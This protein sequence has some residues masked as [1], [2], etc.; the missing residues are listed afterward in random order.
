M[1]SFFKLLLVMLLPLTA[2]AEKIVLPKGL[3]PAVL[4]PW[5]PTRVEL[6]AI[7]TGAPHSFD[8]EKLQKAP[9]YKGKKLA[10]FQGAVVVR[11]H[12]HH[13]SK[14]SDDQFVGL[15]PVNESKESGYYAYQPY[16]KV[17]DGPLSG[18]VAQ[19][20]GYIQMDILGGTGKNAWRLPT[21][22]VEDK[23]ATYV[24][25]TK[26]VRLDIEFLKRN[27]KYGEFSE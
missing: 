16:V 8:V 21:C 27:L 1:K 17:N 13:D 25:G 26:S 23:E 7:E 9:L 3:E 22:L 10:C 12:Y 14:Y 20:G 24:Y 15:V 2:A 11:L 18:S 5:N 4:Q 19:G 6:V